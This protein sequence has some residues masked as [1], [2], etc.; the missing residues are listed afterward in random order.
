[1]LW[2][3]SIVESLEPLCYPL[4]HDIKTIS[5]SGAILSLDFSIFSVDLISATK[6][7]SILQNTAEMIAKDFRLRLSLYYED[8]KEESMFEKDFIIS[9]TNGSSTKSST[10]ANQPP[11]FL[12]NP[13]RTYPVKINGSRG[14]Q[15]VMLGPYFDFEKDK[16]IIDLKCFDCQSAGITDFVFRQVENTIVIPGDTP[17][18]T[19]KI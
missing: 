3:N 17:A 15:S 18:A 16:I 14:E 9:I 11:I 13:A 8:F 6:T 12:K 10:I 2:T 19:Y 4:V 5:E 1:M 7:L